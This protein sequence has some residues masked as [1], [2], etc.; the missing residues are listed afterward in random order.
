MSSDFLK[1]I[2]TALVTFFWIHLCSAHG[3]SCLGKPVFVIETATVT[4]SPNLLK[5]IAPYQKVQRGGIKYYCGTF[6]HHPVMLMNTGIGKVYAAATTAALINTYHPKFILFGGTAGQLDSKLKYGDIVVGS[7][8]FQVEHLDMSVKRTN[9]VNPNSDLIY[10]ALL[11]PNNEILKFVKTLPSFK[12]FSVFYGR[13][14]TTDTFP[15]TKELIEKILKSNSRAVAM[16]DYAVIATCQL[17]NTNCLT[18]RAIS[19]NPLKIIQMKNANEYHV[20]VN[21]RLLTA[22]NLAEYV[23]I[24]LGKWLKTNN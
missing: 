24:F 12:N 20:E 23:R 14:A 21:E 9:H 22:K 2:S 7:E 18:I 13:I 3:D 1:K 4:E 5:M 17:L 6:E 10:S 16:E 15:E 8:V 19:G 11:K